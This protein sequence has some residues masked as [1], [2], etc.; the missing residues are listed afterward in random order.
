MELFFPYSEMS[1]FDSLSKYA[2]VINYEFVDDGV[3]VT[4]DCDERARGIY[5]RFSV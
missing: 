1:S 3:K 2:V 4:A 5:G